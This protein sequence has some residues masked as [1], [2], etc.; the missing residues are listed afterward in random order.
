MEMLESLPPDY[1]EQQEY[2]TAIQNEDEF[3][4]GSQKTKGIWMA[5]CAGIEPCTIVIDLEGTDGRER[6]K[7][8]T[9][10]EKQSA[11][12]A[13]A[14]SDIMLINMW[15]HDIGRELAANKP[16][17]KKVMM[18]LFSPRK[19]TLIFVIRDKTRVNMEMLESFPPDSAEKQ[20]YII[21]IQNKHGF[22]WE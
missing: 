10:F 17:L 8:D 1:A 3:N 22:N 20:E 19:T 16:P 12:F 5:R 2:I 13:L 9:A 15:Y 7:D 14:V 6:G 18:R 11:L 4:W 21:A